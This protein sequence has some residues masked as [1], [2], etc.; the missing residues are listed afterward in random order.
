MQYCI[1]CSM[2]CSLHNT[3]YLEGH[4][5]FQFL[6]ILLSLTCP[7]SCKQNN[8][9]NHTM[10]QF[11]KGS[12]RLRDVPRIGSKWSMQHQNNPC[13]KVLPIF[14]SVTYPVSEYTYTHYFKQ[15]YSRHGLLWYHLKNDK[16]PF[17]NQRC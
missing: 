11:T 17:S 1:K 2:L 15:R 4:E 10:W 12:F 5:G 14:Y 8:K 13:V 3:C 7:R 9:M 6:F 16:I